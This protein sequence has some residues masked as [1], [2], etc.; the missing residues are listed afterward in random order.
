MTREEIRIYALDYLAG[1]LTCKEFV[2]L[3]T[4]YL[5]GSMSLWTR[6]RFQLHL[7]LCRGCRHYLQHM[8]QTIRTL[9]RLPSEPPPPAVQDELLRRFRSWKQERPG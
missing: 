8:K 7:G 4:D 2:E 3:L 1:R 9:G 5:E 6:V